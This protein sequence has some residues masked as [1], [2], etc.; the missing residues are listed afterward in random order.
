MK[1][2]IFFFVLA[3]I[4]SLTAQSQD[5]TDYHL[6]I[7]LQD[8]YG[9]GI[10]DIDSLDITIFNDDTVLIFKNAEYSIQLDIPEGNYSLKAEG[11]K[12]YST[13]I[14]SIEVRSCCYSHIVVVLNYEDGKC[15]PVDSIKYE[16][17]LMRFYFDYDFNHPSF[18]N[19]DGA[20][21]NGYQIGMSNH[22]MFGISKRWD[23][24][25]INSLDWGW[26]QIDSLV[27]PAFEKELDR[28]RYSWFK[29]GLGL[30]N[31]LMISGVNTDVQSD[32]FILNFGATWNMPIMFRYSEVSGSPKQF[33]RG[34][35]KWNEFQAEARL[36]YGPIGFGATYRLTE[37]LKG[38]YPEMPRLM[39]SLTLT[40][41]TI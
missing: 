4:S 2:I 37:Y 35:H 34:I 11:S 15:D 16:I 10:T 40:A 8:E 21:G 24:G 27:A 41:P 6:E 33:K 31:T 9:M 25:T 20:F 39:L 3:I 18:G 17:S 30:T 26:Q 36:T 38:D 19:N 29:W 7:I 5:T 1:H 13:N 23:M 28:S 32:D 14:S 12:Y 22:N